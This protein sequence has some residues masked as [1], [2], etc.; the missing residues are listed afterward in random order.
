M[1]DAKEGEDWRADGPPSGAAREWRRGTGARRRVT[2]EES[3]AM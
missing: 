3:E 1:Q 2:R